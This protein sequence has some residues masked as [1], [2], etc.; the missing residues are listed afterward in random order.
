MKIWTTSLDK[1][2]QYCAHFLATTAKTAG[3]VPV[4]N[5]KSFEF[6]ELGRRIYLFLFP[7]RLM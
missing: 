6:L 3:P 1:F 2:A 4:E 7:C 5:I